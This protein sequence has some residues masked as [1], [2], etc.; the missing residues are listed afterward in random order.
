MDH[1]FT[2]V[3]AF[4]TLAIGAGLAFEQ[5]GA[6][7]YFGEPLITSPAD[8]ETFATGARQFA[9][10][11]DAV[12]G[13]GTSYNERSCMACHAIPMP[14]GA[15]LT[16]STFVRVSPATTDDAGGPVVH[17]LV[18]GMAIAAQEPPDRFSLR[19]SPALFGLGLVEQVPV[20]ELMKE[21]PGPDAIRGRLGGTG[22][23]PGR[24]GRKANVP[25]LAE[26]TRA[27]FAVEL[28]FGPQALRPTGEGLST[29]IEQVTSFVRMLGPPPPRPSGSPAERLG[30][31]LFHGIGCAQCHVPRL[32]GRYAVNG[33]SVE[34]EIAPYSDFLLH[35]M[36]PVLSDGISQGS[37]GGSDFRTA[38]LW[39]LTSF[40]PPYLHDGRATDISQAIASHGGEA[41]MSR[42]RWDSLRH[43]ERQAVLH[44]LQTL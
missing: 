10:V 12:D 29:A 35:D 41:A 42:V 32:A 17:R 31:E 34:F 7:G 20:E 3:G 39:G 43:E 15:G 24:F 8:W 25:D 13:V 2:I 6:G 33:D 27:A 30:R 28:G 40:G 5:A 38:P 18:R 36:G 21:R 16:K 37:A 19:K 4:L 9:R 22:D 1:R 44:F 23:R 14:G 26:F 11:W